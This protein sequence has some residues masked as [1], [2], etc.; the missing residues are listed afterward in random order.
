MSQTSPTDVQRPCSQ[1]W[2]KASAWQPTRPIGVHPTSVQAVRRPEAA[3]REKQRS[4]HWG[5]RSRTV[6]ALHLL[7][8]RKERG[9]R[10]RRFKTS[11]NET[12]FLWPY[13]FLVHLTV[14]YRLKND[15]TAFTRGVQA[16]LHSCDWNSLVP[17][18]VRRDLNHKTVFLE[19]WSGKQ[20]W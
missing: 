13:P 15:A 7:L 1:D 12:S 3:D 14:T 2:K 17:E 19:H 10:S 6:F 18:R 11:P 16:V 20:L 4:E 9:N 8:P 5:P